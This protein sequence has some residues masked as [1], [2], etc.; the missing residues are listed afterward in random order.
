MRST[1]CSIPCQNGQLKWKKL[2]KTDTGQERENALENL[3]YL[4]HTPGHPTYLQN[5][6]RQEKGSASQHQVTAIL[7]QSVYLPGEKGCL[8]MDQ[9]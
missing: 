3:F 6:D 9:G 7:S 5:E 1:A 4:E 8:L 2:D